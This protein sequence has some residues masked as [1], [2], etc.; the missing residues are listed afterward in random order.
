MPG[1]ER[2]NIIAHQHLQGETCQSD[3]FGAR[4]RTYWSK[5]KDPHGAH[6]PLVCISKMTEWTNQWLIKGRMNQFRKSK[7]HK[8]SLSRKQQSPLAYFQNRAQM[9]F[10]MFKHV[11]ISSLYDIFSTCCKF[12][13]S[14]WGGQKCGYINCSQDVYDAALKMGSLDVFK[15][16]PTEIGWYSCPCED[17]VR[18]HSA[19]CVTVLFTHMCWSHTVTKASDK[20]GHKGLNNTTAVVAPGTLGDI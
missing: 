13:S 11:L 18:P 20:K 5:W 8:F 4:S 9:P 14:K 7:K 6:W 2:Y 12:L 1:P 17:M 3:R 16:F 19:G 10:S 15:E